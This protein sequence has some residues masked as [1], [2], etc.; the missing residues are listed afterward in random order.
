MDGEWS[1]SD[2]DLLDAYRDGG[3]TQ[4]LEALFTRYI[5]TVRTMLYQVVLNDAD[6]DDLTQE[7]FVR[8]AQ[9][10]GRFNGNARFSTWLYRIT[11]NQAHSF[12]ASRKRNPVSVSD[13]PPDATTRD[14]TGPDAVA[15]AVELDGRIEAA[16][17]AL[18]LPLRTAVTLTLI[19]GLSVA[20][21]ARIENCA[22]PTLYWRVHEA[23]KRLKRS[24][25]GYL[26]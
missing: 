10:I 14:G 12:L 8:V 16:L 19:Q 4:H 11:M 15:A 23:R 6:A 7:V 21:A 3:Q 13:A 9:G 26:E 25:A 2:E 5:S 17:A 22:L 20:E 24:L 1:A 18:P